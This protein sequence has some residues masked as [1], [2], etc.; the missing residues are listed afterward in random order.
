MQALH[1]VNLTIAKGRFV[2][3]MGPSGSGKSTLLN[4]IGMLDRPSSGAYLLE[5]E[6]VA[7]LS[8]DVMSEIRC[9]KIGMVFQSF[10]LFP[11]F[12]VLENVCVPMQY[13]NASTSVMIERAKTLIEL[14]GLSSRMHH[15]PTQLS[16]GES[17]RTA[18]ARALANNPNLILADEPTGNLDHNTGRDIIEIFRRLALDGKTVVMI[19]HNPDYSDDVERVITLQDGRIIDT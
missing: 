13:A 1:P 7:D 17:Q 3:V 18:I 14:V 2:A 6:N 5:G 10:N 4:L 8:D 19:T 12:T 11:R 9:L 15:R 16:G